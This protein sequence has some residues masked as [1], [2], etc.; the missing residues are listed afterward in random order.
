[1]IL[2]LAMILCFM[3]GCQDKAAMAEIEEFKAQAEV[4]QQN[5]ELVRNYLKTWETRN[6]ENIKE[7][8]APNALIYEPSNAEPMPLEEEKI[9]GVAD[10]HIKVEELLADG[11]KVIARVVVQLTPLEENKV[12]FETDLIE[13]SVIGIFQIEDGKFVELRAESDQVDLLQQLGWEFKQTK[14]IKK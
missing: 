12:F 2:P 8:F 13:Y 3:V 10:F 9:E 6:W 11:N 1:M 7:F 4:E 14:K 5:K